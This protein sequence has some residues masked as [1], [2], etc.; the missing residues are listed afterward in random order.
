MVF[1]EKKNTTS[2]IISILAFICLSVSVWHLSVTAQ[3]PIPLEKNYSFILILSLSAMSSL[4]R[5]VPVSAFISISLTAL[6]VFFSAIMLFSFDFSFT[7]YLLV[8]CGLTFH[9]LSLFTFPIDLLSLLITVLFYF[10]LARFMRL[11]YSNELVNAFKDSADIFVF[12]LVSVTAVFLLKRYD[13][14]RSALINDNNKL[15]TSV[16]QLTAAST[17]FLEYANS[18]EEKTSLE[19]RKRITRDLH[20]LVGQTNTNIIAMMTAVLRKP[21]E[22]EEERMK[23][24][25]WILD[26]SQKCLK[27]SRQVLR[28]IRNL[29]ENKLKGIPRFNELLET[30]R[31]ST[32][33]KITVEWTNLPHAV[34]NALEEVLYSI[35]QESLTNSFHHGQAT[36]IK[37]IFQRENGRIHCNITDNGLEKEY[38]SK[39]IGQ[40][41]LEERINAVGGEIS[42]HPGKMG[43]NVRATLPEI[44]END[45]KI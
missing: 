4:V 15:E 16:R 3:N 18:V 11:D 21:L 30:F 10:F 1:M 40:A 43:Y 34:P 17:S 42:F 6:L 8:F 44:R 36:E 41:G 38:K 20:D 13:G 45:E 7:A 5:K 24:Y 19:E 27:E 14:K 33:M 25:Q 26:I 35:L 23:M 9:F 39:G 32:G 2:F 22:T 29:P 31:I 37:I 12:S 28:D